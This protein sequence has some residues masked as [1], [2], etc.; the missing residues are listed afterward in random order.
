M[1]IK[2]YNVTPFLLREKKDRFGNSDGFLLKFFI[3]YRKDFFLFHFFS[4][5]QEHFVGSGG[6]RWEV[7]Q[8][9]NRK[10]STLTHKW[11]DKHWKTVGPK[12]ILTHRCIHT[13]HVPLFWLVGPNHMVVVNYQ[14]RR[15]ELSMWKRVS[16]WRNAEQVPLGC[17]FYHQV[18]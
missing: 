11:N 14:Q 18:L 15:L 7:I 8:Q 1:C 2:N 6:G 9:K 17:Q 16:G 13:R 4:C 12:E 5:L 10:R 3:S